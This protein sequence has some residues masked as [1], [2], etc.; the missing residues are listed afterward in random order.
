[1]K[2]GFLDETFNSSL[3]TLH[4]DG[5]QTTYLVEGSD[6]T[7]PSNWIMVAA[8]NCEVKYFSQGETE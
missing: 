7:G 5:V 3:K 6:Q 2:P 4:Q 1:L 8:K